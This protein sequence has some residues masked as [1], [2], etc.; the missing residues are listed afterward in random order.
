VAPRAEAPYSRAPLG[1]I[2]QN[3]VALGP[4]GVGEDVPVRP[5]PSGIRCRFACA[6]TG[7]K[8]K[9]YAYTYT[10]ENGDEKAVSFRWAG[11]SGTRK[12]HDEFTMTEATAKLTNEQSEV[13]VMD[14]AGGEP[15]IQI[16]TN[17]WTRP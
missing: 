17:V 11:L 8:D 2:K 9:S 10:V 6:V 15:S 4:D 14:F 13:A 5:S 1:R 12:P 16:K 3:P 7:D